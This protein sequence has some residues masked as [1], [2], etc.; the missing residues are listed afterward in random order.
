MNLFRSIFPTK[1]ARIFLD[2]ADKVFEE[3][4][5][6]DTSTAEVYKSHPDIKRQ[7]WKEIR[8]DLGT[9]I[10][11][12]NDSELSKRLR[13]KFAQQLE[14]LVTDHFYTN[15]E[16]NDRDIYC[17][18]LLNSSREIQ[19]R[20]YYFGLAYDYTYATVLEAII[21]KGWDGGEDS[22]ERLKEFQRGFIDT[23]KDHCNLVLAIARAHGESRELS[24]E[25]KE[26][27]KTTILLKEGMRRALA[28]EKVFD[29]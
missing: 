6:G 23:C 29:E 17:Q 25:E 7:H 3:V 10:G 5:Q 8:N 20:N 9:I 18:H 2:C 12:G 28:G 24:E 11:S 1:N 13:G 26:R 19:D 4:F 22:R 16:T 21:F 14:L 27:G 15:L